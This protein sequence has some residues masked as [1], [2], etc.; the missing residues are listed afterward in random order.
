MAANQRA[1]TDTTL[2]IMPT[3]TPAV[4]SSLPRSLVRSIWRCATS[5]SIT[6]AGA[7]T[8]ANTNARI[9]MVFVGRQASGP[10]VVVLGGF[11]A[12]ATGV[13]AAADADSTLTRA[14][15]W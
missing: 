11:G 14:T 1:T 8:N 13:R 4:A 3:V 15:A 12:R 10:R 9:A 7:N 5:P 2:N 6:P